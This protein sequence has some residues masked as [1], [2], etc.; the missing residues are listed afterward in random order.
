VLASSAQVLKAASPGAAAREANGMGYRI[1]MLLK[2]G[3][4]ARA[5]THPLFS[6]TLIIFLSM[7]PPDIS[8][9]S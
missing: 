8:H 6:S 9:K 7:K 3:V 4:A 2:L 5:Y 1:Q